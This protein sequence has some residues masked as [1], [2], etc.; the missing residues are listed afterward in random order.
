MREAI[1]EAWA[2]RR[3]FES[4]GR[5]RLGWVVD[6]Q[7]GVP[8]IL[9][10][11][12]LVRAGGDGA[13][14]ARGALERAVKDGPTADRQRAIELVPFT[15]PP[16]REALAKAEADPDEAVASAALARRLLSPVKQGGAAP[17]ST[18]R[19]AI[20]AKLLPIAS[21]PGAGAV[22]ARDALARAQVREIVPILER[23]GTAKDAKTRAEAG[24]TLALLG[25]LGRAA[26]VAADLEPHV[27]TTVACAI[28]HPEPA[29]GPR[30][31]A[32][33]PR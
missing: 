3:A 29:Q 22:V 33:A 15:D 32:R 1:V 30:D 26:V 18:D 27:R 28:L 11:S 2:A 17:R 7:R 23:D 10:A 14:E 19:E 25:D 12:A 8:A 21:A 20:V 13:A 4:G 16:L 6:T 24:A 9:A 31:P 5:E